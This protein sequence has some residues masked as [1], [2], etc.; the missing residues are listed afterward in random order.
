MYWYVHNTTEIYYRGT[1]KLHRFS[2]LFASHSSS[3]DLLQNAHC[4]NASLMLWSME[5][6]KKSI[7]HQTIM[8]YL[9]RKW[10]SSSIGMLHTHK[11]R[12]ISADGRVNWMWWAILFLL[13]STKRDQKRTKNIAFFA[14]LHQIRA[15]S[16]TTSGSSS[17]MHIGYFLM[18]LVNSFKKWK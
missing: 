18:L 13:L 12:K 3:V 4:E 15:S 6:I 5:K 16:S 17:Y 2:P 9:V 14:Y 7:N 11:A 10:P 1:V 8:L